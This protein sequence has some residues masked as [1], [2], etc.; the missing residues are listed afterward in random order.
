MR[1]PRNVWTASVGAPMPLVLLCVLIDAKRAMRGQAFGASGPSCWT[2]VRCLRAITSTTIRPVPL[3][4]GAD[5]TFT[6]CRADVDVVWASARECAVPIR[7]V[8]PDIHMY[9]RRCIYR[10]IGGR[11]STIEF[12]SVQ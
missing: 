4:C 7:V 1:V 12:K 2:D 3:P 11:T 6:P 9:I 8:G 5:C 10:S